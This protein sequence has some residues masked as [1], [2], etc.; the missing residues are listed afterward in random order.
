MDYDHT[1]WT[2]L[3]VTRGLLLLAAD[4]VVELVGDLLRQRIPCDQVVR[5]PRD[6]GSDDA[7]ADAQDPEI[8]TQSSRNTRHSD[9]H[10]RLGSV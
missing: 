9:C 2:L 6:D 4:G 7:A 10:R 8:E 5:E 1:C 3:A